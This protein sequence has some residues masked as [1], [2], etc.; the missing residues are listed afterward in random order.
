MDWLG[1]HAAGYLIRTQPNYNS[2]WDE[3]ATSAAMQALVEAGPRLTLTAL[4]EY[5]DE[6]NE[7]GVRTTCQEHMETLKKLWSA[8]EDESNNTSSKDSG[9]LSTYV[10]LVFSDNILF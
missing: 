5:L 1:W 4:S 6:T 8:D 10:S 2:P 7:E 9:L 3:E